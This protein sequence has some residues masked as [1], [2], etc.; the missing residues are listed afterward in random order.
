M[1]VYGLVR[2]PHVAVSF[3]SRRLQSTDQQKTTSRKY[4]V[5]WWFIYVC[6]HWLGD[7]V[8]EDLAMQITQKLLVWWLIVYH[9]FYW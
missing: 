3:V 5:H 6:V 8:V 1:F 9:V 4:S 2:R 7:S